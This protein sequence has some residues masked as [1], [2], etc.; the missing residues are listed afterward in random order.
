MYK[1]QFQFECETENQPGFEPRSLGPKVAKLTIQLHSIDNCQLFKYSDGFPQFWVLNQPVTS[2]LDRKINV[3]LNLSNQLIFWLLIDLFLVL[4]IFTQGKLCIGI[5]N[6]NFPGHD[7]T[8]GCECLLNSLISNNGFEPWATG[9]EFS[10]LP[11]EIFYC[12]NSNLLLCLLF[13]HPCMNDWKRTVT[14]RWWTYNGMV[15]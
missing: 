1:L 9:C 14:Q 6:H 12:F 10:A 13:I 3:Y 4:Y 2:H 8:K 7:W 5:I 15:T 11:F